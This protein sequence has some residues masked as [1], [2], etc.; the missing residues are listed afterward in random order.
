MG[1]KKRTSKKLSPM[2]EKILSYLDSGDF[3]S[4]TL[5]SK[6][7][8]ITKQGV[9]KR[10]HDL[11]KMGKIII[12]KFGNKKYVRATGTEN[13]YIKN[14]IKILAGIKKQKKISYKELQKT[15]LSLQNET[16]SSSQFIIRKG[17]ELESQI[18]FMLPHLL[19]YSVN[20]DGEEYLKFHSRKFKKKA[21]S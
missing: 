5:L 13:I 1:K 10:I 14:M 4:I 11:E 12:A 18:S 7:F 3:L 19:D 21:S 2:D 15:V 16:I 9:E 8:S 17:Q 6:T 20:E